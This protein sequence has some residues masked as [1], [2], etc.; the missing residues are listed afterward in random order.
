MVAGYLVRHPIG[1]ENIMRTRTRFAVLNTAVAA[2]AALVGCAS[3]TPLSDQGSRNVRE[4]VQTRAGPI[5]YTLKGQG[6]VILRL[7]GMS[8][9]CESSMGREALLAAGF[10]TLTP[11]RPGYGKTPSSVG[12][13]AA[14]AADAM[15][16][17]LDTLGT[18][19]V[20]VIANSGGGPTAI[21]L[22]ARHPER[23][24]KLI[25]EDAV[26]RYQREVDPERFDMQKKFY[27]SGYGF[28]CFMMKVVATVSPKAMA[29]Q[30]MALFGT[31]DPDEA[32]R[33][34]SRKDL[35]AIRSFYVNMQASWAAGA[36]NDMEHS[37]GDA[38]LSCIKAP[39]LIVH[40]REDKAVN[41]SFAEYSHANIPAS[42]LWEAPSWSHFIS[43]GHGADQVDRKVVE[44][45]K[46][47]G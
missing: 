4:V 36:S 22:A 3:T 9:D 20:D 10:S 30:T 13:T 32:V 8:E 1:R 24:R 25:L 28:M 19:E 7:T 44:F 40:S 39:T 38:V 14:E 26:S 23:V 33:E 17:L 34:M 27:G 31:H 5:E 41:F 47:N 2:C 18:A 11:S 35:E 45:L 21:H 6:P 16:A 43:I 42:E 37:T 15:V 12:R 29:R 46:D